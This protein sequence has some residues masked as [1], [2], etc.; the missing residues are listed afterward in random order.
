[1][2]L[3]LLVLGQVLRGRIHVS[4]LEVVVEYL[5][6]LVEEVAGLLGVGVVAVDHYFHFLCH[7]C[8]FHHLIKSNLSQF[9]RQ[10][11]NAQR[12]QPQ[13]EYSRCS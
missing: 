10:V 12:Q 6:L 3:V 2:D 9:S 5:L 7:Y 4:H 11:Y 13:C 1:M 8:L